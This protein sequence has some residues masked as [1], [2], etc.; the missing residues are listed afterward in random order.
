M[1]KLNQWCIDKIFATKTQT[2]GLVVSLSV[3][4]G[5]I[6]PIIYLAPPVIHKFLMALGFVVLALKSSPL[7]GERV[8][9]F[10]DPRRL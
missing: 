8:K 2:L 6:I 10:V 3:T 4:L 5:F 9:L 1:L 7:V